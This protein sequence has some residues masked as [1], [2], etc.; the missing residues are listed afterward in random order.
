MAAFD[1]AVVSWRIR[2][3]K[4]VADAQ[5]G[6]RAF[7]ECRACGLAGDQAVSEFGAVVRLD[8][9]NRERELFDTVPDELSRGIGAVFLKCLQIPKTAV[10]IQECVLIVSTLFGGADQTALRNIFDI[11]LDSLAWVLHL[12]VGLW[13]ILGIWQ[14]H[15]YLAALSQKTI[16]TGNGTGVTPPPQ[17]DPEYHQP[18]GRIL[19]AH[20]LY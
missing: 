5:L 16:Q 15:R 2:T 8:A 11:D 9:L 4:L 7:K 12:L 20:I 10:F 14:F 1:L 17:F 6:Q 19:A 18:C 13:D 3:D